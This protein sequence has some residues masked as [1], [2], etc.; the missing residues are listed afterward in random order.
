MSTVKL[1]EKQAAEI[2]SFYH[3]EIQ[4]VIARYNHLKSTLESLGEVAP[5]L[6]INAP[7]GRYAA[8]RRRRKGKPGPNSVWDKK[9]LKRLKAVNKPLTYEEL[10]DDIMALEGHPAE[11]RPNIKAAIVN[12]TYRLRKR[13]KKIDTFSVGKREKY[14]ALKAWFDAEG[15][16]LEV[17]ENMVPKPPKKEEGPKRPVGRPKGSKN[18]PGAKKPGPKPKPKAPVAKKTAAKKSVKAKTTKAAPKKTSAKKVTA[19]KSTAKKTAAKPATKKAAP[20]KSTTKKATANK[21]ATKKAAPAKAKTAAK[22][23]KGPVV[24]KN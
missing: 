6:D 8:P 4:K 19:A 9:I 3:A 1:D 12:V 7:V 2:A 10:T 24:I 16:I 22:K 17:Y 5:V 20:K 11:K 15:K 14:I 13:D 18:R 21:P 23:S